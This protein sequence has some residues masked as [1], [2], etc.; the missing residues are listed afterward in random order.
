MVEGWWAIDQSTRRIDS[1]D[2]A[3]SV[4]MAEVRSERI[5]RLLMSPNPPW[6]EDVEN[7]DN[8]HERGWRA[9]PD[10]K[11]TTVTTAY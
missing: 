7:C 9:I 11:E 6:S 5:F 10:S 8:E 3:F 2:T 4:S 1:D